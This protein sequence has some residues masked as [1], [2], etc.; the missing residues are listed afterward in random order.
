M[1]TRVRVEAQAAGIDAP[2]RTELTGKDGAPLV[3]PDQSAGVAASALTIME[4]V[5]AQ[6]EETGGRQD[7]E[8]DVADGG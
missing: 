7:E 3:T 4:R 5:L 6:M 1:D 8:P 2:E